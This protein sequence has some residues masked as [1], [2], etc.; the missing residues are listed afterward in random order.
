MY[1]Y[2]D[3][4][5]QPPDTCLEGC[6]RWEYLESD[7]CVEDQ[8]SADAKWAAGKA[9]ANA[10]RNCASPGKAPGQYGSWCYCKDA[11]KLNL[12]TWDYCQAEKAQPEQ[13]N[14]QLS[15]EGQ[16]VASFATFGPDELD[17]NP[18]CQ[19]ALAING[20]EEAA[21][22]QATTN[23][24]TVIATG[25]THAHMS[26]VGD[27][28]V[29]LHFVRLDHLKPRA[30]YTYSCT[31]GSYNR[32]W[33][34]PATFRAPYASGETRL[35][36][37]GDMGVYSWNNM[38]NLVR[39]CESEEIDAVVHIGD[40]A[41]NE[42]D[43]DE[44]RG[45]GY[46]QA[47]QR[48]LS[49]CPWMPIVGNHEY[50]SNEQL[51]R[52]M[53]STWE[54]WNDISKEDKPKNMDTMDT[55]TSAL[56]ALLSKAAFAGAGSQGPVPSGTSRWFSTDIGL[57][58]L[59]ALDLNLYFGTDSNNA[60][61]KQQQIDWLEKDLAAANENRDAVPWIIAT[62]HYPLYCSECASQTMTASWYAEG[63]V[64]DANGTEMEH[65]PMQP[66][67]QARIVEA[68][69]ACAAVGAGDSS[70]STD[71][72]QRDL[73]CDA[74]WATTVGASTAAAIKDIVPVIHSAGVDIYMAGHWHYYESLYPMGTPPAGTGGPPTQKNFTEPTSTVH[75][76]TGNGGPPG[77]D[78]MDSP[79]PA[80]RKKSDKYGYGRVRAFN[81]THFRF[82]QVLNGFSDEGKPGEVFDS[83]TII[84]Q[85]HGP[86]RSN[87]R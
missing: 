85:T 67:D 74:K 69:A 17:G 15:A 39:D 82:E 38:G 63:F 20:S 25:V 65:P 18:S 11:R 6:A 7:G 27:R 13:M 46:M 10:G 71:T 41:Y 79:M 16:L 81:K 86:F 44:R 70:S 73:L 28:T 45:D 30:S 48:I 35:A 57:V 59:V 64:F 23:Q 49:R 22:I 42:G 58:H 78:T 75:I 61:L 26:P 37:F 55:A 4:L 43:N 51:S 66:E 32:I 53:D 29:Y 19:Y 52:Y 2:V 50:Y 21:W 33:S 56:G 14:L 76:T 87:H 77:K 34:P 83:F 84:Q 9:P 3:S 5:R 24:T 80:L 62:S 68:Q 12:S 60:T 40:H 47:Y 72:T 1:D 54:N 8:A 36:M 31:S